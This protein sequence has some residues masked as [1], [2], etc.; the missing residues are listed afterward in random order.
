MGTK[1]NFWKKPLQ[2]KSHLSLNTMRGVVAVIILMLFVCS[3]KRNHR[4]QPGNNRNFGGGKHHGG[5]R[6]HGGGKHHGGG[7]GRHH[8]GGGGHHGGHKNP[9]WHHNWYEGGDVDGCPG[10]ERKKL[11]SATVGAAKADLR[12][13]LF[14]DRHDCVGGCDGCINR[15]NPD[16]AGFIFDSLDVMDKIY[17]ESYKLDM[18]RADF[19]ILT[20]VT[21]LEDSLQFNNANLT[22]SYIQPVRINYKY[23]RCDCSTS[24]VTSVRR[25]FPGGH[26]GYNQVMDFFRQEFGF[27]EKE[28]VAIMGAHTLGGASGARGSGFEWFWKEDG[29]AAARMNNRYYSLLTNASV[30]WR[31]VDRSLVTGLGEERWQWEAGSTPEGTPA[32]FMLNA[33][34]SLIRNIQPGVGGRSACAFQSCPLSPSARYVQEFAEDGDEWFRQFLKVWDK[35]VAKGAKK[36]KNPE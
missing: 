6:H 21:A 15:D 10:V 33:D 3:S 4:H 1:L 5:G 27:N 35:M 23:G 13:K 2:Y 11:K 20:G 25:D 9:G 18:S 16:N 22:S 34:V 31:N 8:G 19:Y 7:G 17:E 14:L 28:S 26:F 24:P 36:L 30:T 29:V 32:P 12:S